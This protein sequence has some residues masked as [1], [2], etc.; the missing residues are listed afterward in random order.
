MI[1]IVAKDGQELSELGKKIPLGAIMRVLPKETKEYPVK[2]G[3]TTFYICREHACQPPVN[4][5][6]GNIG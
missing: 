5:L 2:N 4:E 3:K 1:T 6:D